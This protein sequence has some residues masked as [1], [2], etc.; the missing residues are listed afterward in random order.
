MRS[1]FVSLV[2]R[3]N[4]GKSSIL[5]AA[6]GRK[7]SIVSDKPQTTRTRVRAVVHRSD[8]QIVFVDTPG[9]HKPV[10]ALGKRVNA[11]A[12]DASREVDVTCLV[13]D[14]TMPFGRGDQFVAERM[15]LA[16]GA[17]IVNK[18][19]RAPRSKVLK[20]LSAV[21]ALD[22]AAY[23]PLS[24]KTGEGVEVFLDWLATRLPEGEPLYPSDVIRETPDT[25]W[26]ADLVREELLSRMREEL[27]YSIAT[28]VTEY[29]WPRIRCEIVVERDSQKGMV[30]GKGGQVL[31][32][33]GTAVRLQLAK[34]AHIELVVVVDEGWQQRLDRI[35]RLGY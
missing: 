32:E 8:A 30:I 17:I 15:N 33:V 7:V 22:A 11:T 26:V 27:P 35:E 25:L 29:E 5:N 16:T 2:G 34:G 19:D 20:Q 28:R 10:S 4:V 31:K 13:I 24:A 18:I 12:L 21:A 9:I 23:F 1:G 14:A 6:C 3:P